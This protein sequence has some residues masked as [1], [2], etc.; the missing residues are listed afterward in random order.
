MAVV[1]QNQPGTI[2]DANEAVTGAPK[3]SKSR[4]VALTCSVWQTT[5]S[6]TATLQISQWP[7]HR[8]KTEPL[9]HYLTSLRYFFELQS[10]GFGCGSHLIRVWSECHICSGKIKLKISSEGSEGIS[11]KFCTI[12]KFSAVQYLLILLLQIANVST[13]LCYI[14]IQPHPYSFH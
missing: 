7:P 4:S 6:P 9:L 5:F 3:L 2:Q 11:V 8:Q 1:E 12:K 13:V 10:L 14:T